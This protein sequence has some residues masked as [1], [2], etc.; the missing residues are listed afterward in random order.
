MNTE[1]AERAAAARQMLAALVALLP[2]VDSDEGRYDQQI[3]KARA[4]ITQ[5][6]DA[7]VEE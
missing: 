5:A 4:A 6:R 2:C 7:G 1:Q 3:A